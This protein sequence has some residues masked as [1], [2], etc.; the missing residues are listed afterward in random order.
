MEFGPRALGNRSILADARDP[1]MKN[2][3]NDSIKFRENWRPFAPSVLVEK[4]HEYF[5]PDAP[6]PFMILTHT[7]KAEKRNVIPAVTHADNSARI[8]TVDRSVNPRYW[9]LITE[10]EKLTG[11]GLVMNTSFNLR[12]EPIVCEPKDAIRTFFS[13]GLDYLVMGDCLVAKDQAKPE[14]ADAPASTSANGRV[15]AKE[16]VSAQ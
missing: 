7:V 8:Q 4:A 12:G 11:V 5:E 13:S 3:V 15:E 6:S 9:E 2:K 1:E 14:Q 16:L 10:F